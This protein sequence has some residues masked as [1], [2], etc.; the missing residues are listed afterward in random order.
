MQYIY[1]SIQEEFE[2]TKRSTEAVYRRKI[3]NT[4]VKR[5]KNTRTNNDDGL[6]SA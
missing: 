6:I 1:N 3:G 4:M 5:K 2:E